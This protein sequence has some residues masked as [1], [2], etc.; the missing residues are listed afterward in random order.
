MP[1]LHEG[2]DY[3]AIAASQREDP[4]VQ[5][6]CTAYCTAITGLKLEDVHT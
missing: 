3:A 2:V 4:D 5:A 1:E 6:Y